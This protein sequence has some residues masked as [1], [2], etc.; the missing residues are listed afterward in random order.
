MHMPKKTHI[1]YADSKL[2]YAFDCTSAA[3]WSLALS[4]TCVLAGLPCMLWCYLVAISQQLQGLSYHLQLHDQAATLQCTNM[5]HILYSRH[6]LMPHSSAAVQNSMSPHGCSQQHSV[7]LATMTLNLIYCGFC[8][9]F[10]HPVIQI[11]A[12][13]D[14]KGGIAIPSFLPSIGTID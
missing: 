11:N 8:N 4:N 12:Y 9:G 3:H 14:K 13:I 6:T 2:I 10:T 1:W 5:V 7:W